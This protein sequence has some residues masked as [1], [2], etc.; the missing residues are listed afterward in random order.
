MKKVILLLLFTVLMLAPL[1]AVNAAGPFGDAL[2]K[3]STVNQTV[4]LSGNFQTSIA[5]IIQ[6]ALSLVGTIFLIL[7]VY[8]GILW[9]T[10]SGNEEKVTK[11]KE[12]V[13]QAIIG[14]AI[15]LGA[16]AITVFVTGKLNSNPAAPTSTAVTTDAQCTAMGGTAACETGPNC[17]DGKI[18][19]GKCTDPA[20]ICCP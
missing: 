4:K 19:L 1:A 10:A 16:Y 20:E 2:G 9:M 6:G 5:A 11:A 18:P 15:T 13:T 17:T 8:A 14:L 3:L 12:I 7:A